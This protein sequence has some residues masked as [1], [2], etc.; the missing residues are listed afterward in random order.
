M[1]IESARQQLIGYEL[2]EKEK[3]RTLQKAT[4][5]SNWKDRNGAFNRN[6]EVCRSGIGDE[7][8]GSYFENTEF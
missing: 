5:S 4:K 8:N 6:G 3:L 7:D 2:K 1:Q